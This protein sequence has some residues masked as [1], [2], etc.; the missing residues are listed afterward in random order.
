MEV[1]DWKEKV[2]KVV[3]L[4][5][6]LEVTVR[7][8]SPMVLMEVAGALPGV[9]NV[10]SERQGDTARRILEAGVI[11][12]KIGEGEN[13]LSVYDLDQD[14]F[15]TVMDAIVGGPKREGEPGIPLA[16]TA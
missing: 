10:T 3:T 16:P 15:N 7:R 9:E 2:R 12:P 5:D 1:K 11:S 13:E 6:G 14:D 4:K 8:L